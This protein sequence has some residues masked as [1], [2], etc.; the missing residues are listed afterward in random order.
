MTRGGTWARRRASFR[1]AGLVALVGL[2]WG[3]AALGGAA[4]GTGGA[5][6]PGAGPNGDADQARRAAGEQ[7]PGPALEDTGHGPPV[8]PLPSTASVAPSSTS[9]AGGSPSG[10]GSSEATTGGASGDPYAAEEAET[11]APPLEEFL[12]RYGY[13]IVSEEREPMGGAEVY[14]ILV[15]AEDI[16]GYNEVCTVMD[17]ALGERGDVGDVLWVAM[18]DLSDRKEEWDGVVLLEA[19]GPAEAVRD[20][21]LDVDTAFECRGYYHY[22]LGWAQER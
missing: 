15:A 22:D 7:A 14:H 13:H 8:N 11:T 1:R 2:V 6:S 12:V 5:G 16:V 18:F 21:I 10:G 4:C 9:S 20:G 17:Y 3:V 19:G